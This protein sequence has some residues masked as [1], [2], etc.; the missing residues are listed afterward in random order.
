MSQAF[1]T[2]LKCLVATLVLSVIVVFSADSP[3]VYLEGKLPGELNK[4]DH[5]YEKYDYRKLHRETMLPA[6]KTAAKQDKIPYIR[7]YAGEIDQLL[8]KNQLIIAYTLS[9]CRNTHRKP[10]EVMPNVQAQTA[11]I[12]NK[13]SGSKKPAIMIFLPAFDREFT[14]LKPAQLKDL[15]LTIIIHEYRH[16]TKQQNF[17]EDTPYPLVVA[18]E[19]QIWEEQLKEMFPAMKKAG[20]YLQPGIE[21]HM[22]AYKQLKTRHPSQWLSYVRKNI[23]YPQ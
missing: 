3:K 6:F 11:W 12:D 14:A 22:A 16:I 13:N 8:K 1:A 4:L 15:F 2:N 21:N 5:K 10:I 23:A 17:S 19:A 7:K 18:S 20:R 9:F